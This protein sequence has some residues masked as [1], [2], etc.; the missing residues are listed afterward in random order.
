MKHLK[1][2]ERLISYTT[3]CDNYITLDLIKFNR[4]ESN[5][6]D[7]EES[8]KL[9]KLTDL[10][11]G[12]IV[13]FKGKK[14]GNSKYGLYQNTIKNVLFSDNKKNKYE[15]VTENDEHYNIDNRNPIIIYTP[16]KELKKDYMTI[17]DNRIVLDLKKFSKNSSSTAYKL[18]KI[19]FGKL[20]G[21]SGRRYERPLGYNAT[22]N[23]DSYFNNKLYI[24]DVKLS[25]I[26]LEKG[27]YTYEFQ[28]ENNEWYVINNNEPITIYELE[29]NSRK[30]NL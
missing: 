11:V 2:F 8:S 16:E 3:K 23:R 14:I 15:F 17:Y 7:N 22:F 21:F 10:L 28:G 29:T 12:N 19:L 27:I 26:F 18:W 9:Y 25:D 20:V 5:E 6:F 24:K 13:G 4:A 1:T 30:F